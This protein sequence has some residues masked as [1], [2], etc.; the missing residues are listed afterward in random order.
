MKKN[1]CLFIVVSL[2]IVVC[3]TR[4]FQENIFSKVLISKMFQLKFYFPF[5][6]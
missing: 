4:Y 5:I 6:V 3:F 1:L 2:K